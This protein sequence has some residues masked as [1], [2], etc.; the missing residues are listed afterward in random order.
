MRSPI[1]GKL[2]NNCLSLYVLQ[3][4][5]LCQDEDRFQDIQEMMRSV[6]FMGTPHEGSDQA[7]HLEDAQK[8]VSLFRAGQDITSITR[9]L[10]VYS[11]TTMDINKSF[12][13]KASKDLTL[14]C[15]F[16]TLPTRLP[17]GER[18]VNPRSLFQCRE[19][20]C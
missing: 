7:K 9:E 10:E 5:I 12:M 8:I 13:K 4:L 19:T 2:A 16:E 1:G 20:F 14:L 3:A 11:A 15:F 18:M 6:I 17:Q